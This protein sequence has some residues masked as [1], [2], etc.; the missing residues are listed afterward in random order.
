MVQVNIEKNVIT[1]LV[2]SA[3]QKSGGDAFLS[4]NDNTNSNQ[5]AAVKPIRSVENLNELG[6]VVMTIDK[7][8]LFEIFDS[9]IHG[10]T[11]RFLIVD[12]SGNPV[13]LPDSDV[14]IPIKRIHNSVPENVTTYLNSIDV[15]DVDY[16][17]VIHKSRQTDWELIAVVPEKELY[18]NSL[19]I[20][21]NILTYILI[22]VFVIAAL[23]TATN[24]RITKPITLLADA[25]DRVASGDTKHKISFSDKNEIT[26]IADNF[27]HMVDEVQAAK[28]RIFTTQQRLYE[29][30][31]EKKQFEVILLQSQINSHFLYNTLSCIRAMSRKGAEDEVSE[32]ITSLVGM[33]RYASNMQ[34]KSVIQDELN[35]IKNYV[36]IQR[37]RLGEQLQLIFDV[38]D[39]ILDYE[40][41]KMTLQPVVENS[42]LHGFDAQ[43]D[44]WSIKVSVKV[45]NDMMEIRIID[46]GEGIDSEQLKKL[47]DSLNSK[48]SLLETDNKKSSIGLINIRNR[49]HSLY[50][51]EYGVSVRSFKKLGTAVIIKIPC[52]RSDD[53]VFG[54]FD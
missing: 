11:M 37:M 5:I 4:V 18:S 42:I 51:E 44:K 48:N 39:D 49:I 35:N 13:L 23:T 17:Y 38:N 19:K 53:Y 15:N 10:A 8:K 54:A 7:N 28:K 52:K 22:I 43:S 50:G 16:K 36:Y 9:D 29:T 40:I 30:E 21:Y 45:Y 31:L 25:I 33:L 34:E 32:M 46:N 1:D 20:G 2:S 12:S 6:Y 27:N 47:N 41:P 14:K 24:F 3:R 26:M